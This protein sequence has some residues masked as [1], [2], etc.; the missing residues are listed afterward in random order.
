M[1]KQNVITYI[2]EIDIRK[3]VSRGRVNEIGQLSMDDT[4]LRAIKGATR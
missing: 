4:V 3:D 2:D 1:G